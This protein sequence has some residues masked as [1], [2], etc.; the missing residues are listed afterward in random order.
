MFTIWFPTP[1]Q[2]FADLCSVAN[3]SIFILD[4]ELH[5]FYLHGRSP[6]G[7]AE[8]NARWLQEQLD[9]GVSKGARG[10][11]KSE[12]GDTAELQTFEMFVPRE[13]RYNYDAHKNYKTQTVNTANLQSGATINKPVP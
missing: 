4:S 12:R 11:L 7:V 2:D 6:S 8:G 9:S 13:L 10:F 1:I 5:G 3:I